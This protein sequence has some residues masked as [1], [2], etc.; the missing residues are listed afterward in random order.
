MNNDDKTL[1]EKYGITCETKMVYTYK[2]YR[3]D[4]LQDAL[5]YA[6]IDAKRNRESGS[7]TAHEIM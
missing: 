3:Y 1:M 7:A 2:K 6:E 5:R 4:N